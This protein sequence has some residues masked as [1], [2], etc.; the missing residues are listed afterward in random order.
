MDAIGALG[1]ARAFA[2]GG[3]T[4]RVMYEPQNTFWQKKFSFSQEKETTIR[5]FYDKLF[6]L[7]DL[8]NTDTA[9]EIANQR[10]Q[11]MRSFVEEFYAEWNG[12]R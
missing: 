12:K 6:Q 5:H 8:M 2:F 1:I 10:D 7:K 11:V 4:G 9:K 3:N